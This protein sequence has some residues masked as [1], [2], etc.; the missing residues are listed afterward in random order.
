[1]ERVVGSGI[2]ECESGLVHRPAAG[3]C[4]AYEQSTATRPPSP[5]PEQDE[6]ASDLDCSAHAYGYC[7]FGLTR[8]SAS[9]TPNRCGYG[10]TSDTECDPGN[11]CVCTEE[12]GE[13]RPATCEVDADCGEGSLCAEY[14]PADGPS[15]GF[16]CQV[17]ADR[18]QLNSQC[19]A[20][21]SC[22]MTT[23]GVRGCQPWLGG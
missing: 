14:A 3:T 10:C 13:C 12:R 1:M 16:A 19:P 2:V 18:C 5:A 20:M 17:A 7:Q 22:V 23:A 21:N 4:L 11:I 8:Y 9:V 15:L 6:C